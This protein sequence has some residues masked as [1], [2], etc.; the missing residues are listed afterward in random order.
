MGVVGEISESTKY[1]WTKAS[2]FD[3][4]PGENMALEE[5][6]TEVMGY[7]FDPKNMGERVD[8]LTAEER[9]ALRDLSK[10]NKDPN[11][12][13]QNPRQRLLFCGGF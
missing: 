2:E 13:R 6:L 9:E 3:P 10:C 11:N 4:V 12:P 1:P 7:I 5:F 8:N